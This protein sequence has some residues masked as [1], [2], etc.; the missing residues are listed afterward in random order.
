MLRGKPSNSIP[1]FNDSREQSDD[2]S[3]SDKS[4][5]TSDYATF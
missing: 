5:F 1:V 4:V 2:V 3:P